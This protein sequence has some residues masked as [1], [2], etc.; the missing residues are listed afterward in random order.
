MLFLSHFSLVG[1]LAKLDNL[2]RVAYC[3]LVSFQQ[4]RAYLTIATPS[5]ALSSNISNLA[6][7]PP[8][9]RLRMS[10]KGRVLPPFAF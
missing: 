9:L 8:H 5:P 2:E 10:L 7:P 6:T 1:E 3:C 4:W